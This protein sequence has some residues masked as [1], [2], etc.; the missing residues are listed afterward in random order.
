MKDRLQ[1]DGLGIPV[2]Y[3]HYSLLIKYQQRSVK[4][5]DKKA[6]S[7]SAVWFMKVEAGSVSMVSLLIT[8]WVCLKKVHYP[9]MIPAMPKGY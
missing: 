1:I 6:T 8:R 4:D 2:L 7:C 3:I 9:Y 5:S